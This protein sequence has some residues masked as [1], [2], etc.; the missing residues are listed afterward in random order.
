MKKFVASA[1]AVTM[2]LGVA[3]GSAQANWFSKDKDDNVVVRTENHVVTKTENSPT[4]TTYRTNHGNDVT[5][6]TPVGYDATAH[7]PEAQ[8]WNYNGSS[9]YRGGLTGQIATYDANGNMVVRPVRGASHQFNSSLRN[10]D[11]GQ[12]AETRL[13]HAFNN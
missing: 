12:S 10:G 8:K 4:S 1:L 6:S 2:V 7:D 9:A 3:A 5:V 11:I 13:N